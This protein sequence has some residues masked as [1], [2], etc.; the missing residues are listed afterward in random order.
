MRLATAT[1]EQAAAAWMLERIKDDYVE[2]ARKEYQDRRDLLISALHSIPGVEVPKPEGAFYVCAKFP[3][4]DADHFAQW[5][6]SDFS[7]DKATVFVAPASGFYLEPSIGRSQLR[8][9]YV[10]NRAELSQA[11][12]V[13]G[14]ALKVYPDISKN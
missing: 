9:A 13:L 4:K 8:L 12:D 3:V 6:L 5:L 7:H 14:Q 10:V 1:L 2:A 11:V